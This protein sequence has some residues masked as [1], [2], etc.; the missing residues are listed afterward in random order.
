MKTI[1]MRVKVV[2]VNHYRRLQLIIWEL[3]GVEN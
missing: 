1:A 3:L 2:P